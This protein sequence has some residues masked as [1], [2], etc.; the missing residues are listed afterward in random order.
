MRKNLKFVRQHHYHRS[1][2]D[3]L[4]HMQF[5]FLQQISDGIE[6]FLVCQ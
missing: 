2:S 1:C 6:F 3:L 5:Q 4:Y